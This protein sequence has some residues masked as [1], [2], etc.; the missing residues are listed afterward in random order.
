M[1]G[2]NAFAHGAGLHQDGILKAA[3]T[4]E[5]IRPERVGAPARQLPITRHSGRKGVV[6]RLEALGIEVDDSMVNDLLPFIKQH[7]VR[8]A[9]LEDEDL[10]ALVEKLPKR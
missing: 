1:V 8:V 10:I 7:L 5:I 2:G 3:S 6:A 4:Y 9:V